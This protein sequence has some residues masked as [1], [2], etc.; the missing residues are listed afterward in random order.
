[1]TGPSPEAILAAEKLQQSSESQLLE[2]LG[3]RARAVQS[4]PALGAH[5]DLELAPD[6]TVMGWREDA[7]E[8]GRQLFSRWEREA[9]NLLCGAADDDTADRKKLGEAFGVSDV[10]V[11]ASISTALAASFGLAAPVAAVIAAILVKRFFRPGYEEFCRFWGKTL[12]Q[13]A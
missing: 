5:Y 4:D 13:P 3:A 12:D 8:L 10:I 2:E 7:L 1:M 9:Y 11:A 6:D